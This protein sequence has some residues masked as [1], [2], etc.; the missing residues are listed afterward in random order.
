MHTPSAN[1]FSVSVALA[2]A[3]PQPAELM[4]S[5]TLMLCKTSAVATHE[6]S[7]ANIA[8]DAKEKKAMANLLLPPWSPALRF[9]T[10]ASALPS[11]QMIAWIVCVPVT[12]HRPRVS[13]CTVQWYVCCVATRRCMHAQSCW[14]ALDRAD[15]ATWVPGC[16]PVLYRLCVR[17]ASHVGMGI[18]ACTCTHRGS[19]AKDKA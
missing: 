8:A 5:M 19:R 1:A 3:P 13:V 18:A 2:S 11:V 14:H 17:R 7:Q 15:P 10:R 12:C 16:A 6:R 9:A 4:A